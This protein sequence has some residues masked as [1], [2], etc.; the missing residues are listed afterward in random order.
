[1]HLVGRCVHLQISIEQEEM[2]S[3]LNTNEANNE[4]YCVVILEDVDE[5]MET[6]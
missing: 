2:S 1:M 4:E 3:F 5:V 6:M